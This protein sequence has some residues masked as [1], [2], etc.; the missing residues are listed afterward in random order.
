MIGRRL[1]SHGAALALVVLAVGLASG[2]GG[3]EVDDRAAAA[4]TYA[5]RVAEVTESTRAELATTSKAADYRDAGAAAVTT[6][7]YAA[8]IRQAADEL[9]GSKPPAAVAQ[10]HRELVALYRTTADRLDGIAG[11]FAALTDEREL[12][13][14]AQELS[15]EVQTYSTAEAQ[16]R[17]AIDAELA[18]VVPT[19]PAAPN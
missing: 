7:A 13:A 9:A 11:R 8:A 2:C 4:H 12:T 6:R 10:K 5:T 19:T 17:A 14:R 3:R 16:L 15:A 18:K 1:R